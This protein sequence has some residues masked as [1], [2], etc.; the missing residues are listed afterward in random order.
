MD[1]APF[2][3]MRL[4]ADDGFGNLVPLHPVTLIDG[5]VV[6]S[7]SEEWRHEC[8]ARAVLA[9]TPLAARRAYLYGTLNQWNKPAGGILQR[10]GPEA[11]KRLEETMIALWRARS[12][13][14]K[15]ALADRPRGL[16]LGEQGPPKPAAN[17]N[18]KGNENAICNL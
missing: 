7:Y 10:R 1:E 18:T 4:F 11:V 13:A 6:S 15:R 14:A 9:M 16:P 5:R 12:D 2:R 8:E 3:P 17:D